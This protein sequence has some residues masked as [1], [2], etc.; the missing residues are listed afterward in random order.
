MVD[1]LEKILFSPAMIRFGT[2]SLVVAVILLIASVAGS[3]AISIGGFYSPG[4]R[5]Q[6]GGTKGDVSDGSILRT[7]IMEMGE[8][9]RRCNWLRRPSNSSPARISMSGPAQ[10]TA[11]CLLL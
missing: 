1:S 7:T 3:I 5:V 8:W 9:N 2:A 6:L 11:A 10:K 4:G